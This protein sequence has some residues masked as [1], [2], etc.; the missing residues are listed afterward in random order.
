MPNK[1]AGISKLTSIID[2]EAIN[3]LQL[4]K[5]DKNLYFMSPNCE[6]LIRSD[7]D[8]ARSMRPEKWHQI[9][10]AKLVSSDRFTKKYVEISL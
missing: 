1:V 7:I 5:A 3:R 4:I 9:F 10:C 2:I 6:S 8:E